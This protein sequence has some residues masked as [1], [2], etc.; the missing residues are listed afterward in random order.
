T[1]CQQT[2]DDFFSSQDL[3]SILKGRPDLIFLDGMHLFEFLLRDFYNCEKLAD[4]NTLIMMHDCM[5]LNAE[6]ADRSE[7]RAYEQGKNTTYPGY[8]T[9]DVWK[10]VRIL[11]KYRPELKM[12]CL[13]CPPLECFVS[14]D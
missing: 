9:G 4:R 7:V 14:L 13:E 10:I 5:P 11:Q 3:L 2:S 8:W 6:M 12:A 1:L